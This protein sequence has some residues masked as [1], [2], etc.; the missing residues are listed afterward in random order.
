MDEHIVPT[1]PE[2]TKSGFGEFARFA[3]VV[4][5]IVGVVR[6]F[7]AQP[8]IVSGASMVPT[9]QNSNYL[10]IDE[11]SYRFSEPKRGD[12]I[13]FHP[14]RDPSVYYIK[15]VI[16]LPGDTVSISHGEVTIVDASHPDGFKLSEPYITK[17][18]EGDFSKT[19]VLPD[20]Y[21]VMG[22][23]RPASFDSRGWGLLPRKNITGRALLRLFPLNKVALFPGENH[24]Y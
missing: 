21:F 9:F 24:N 23:N 7:V 19:P 2:S 14:P 18:F 8:F 4:I 5:M 15:R 13:I 3:I 16:G 1:K 10:I 11:L 6:A 22:D 17:D 20:Q 12:V